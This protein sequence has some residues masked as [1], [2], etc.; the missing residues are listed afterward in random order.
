MI[1][2]RILVVISFQKSLNSSVWDELNFESKFITSGMDKREED[3][4]SH[5]IRNTTYKVQRNIHKSRNIINISKKMA[6]GE[7]GAAALNWRQGQYQQQEQQQ[8][9]DVAGQ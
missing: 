1:P 4:K 6:N 3:R 9:Q 2:E 8:N 7:E 5:I